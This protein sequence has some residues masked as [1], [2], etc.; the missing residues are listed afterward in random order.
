MNP[1]DLEQRLRDHFADRAAREP[2]GEPDPAPIVA[3]ARAGA[4]RPFRRTG[5]LALVGALA[6]ACVLAVVAVVVTG[7]DEDKVEMDPATPTTD[8][9]RPS[10]STTTA[11]TTPPSSQPP[12]TTV[13]DASAP[14]APVESL[15]VVGRSVLGG[16]D[17]AR[18]VSYGRGLPPAPVP[19]RAGDQYQV[20][21]LVGP[22]FTAT[23]ADPEQVACGGDDTYLVSVGEFDPGAPAMVAVRGVAAPRPRPVTVLDP[24][25]PEYRNAAAQVLAGLGVDVQDPAVRQ[26][27]RVDLDGDGTDEVLVRAEVADRASLRPV[28]G[29][30]SVVFLRR[31][32]GGAVQNTVV[33]SDVPVI[34][35][36]QIR[37]ITVYDLASVADLN[38]D[39]RMEV[40]LVWSYY[41]G[42][43]VT[44]YE[45]Q[46]DRLAPVLEA[47]CGA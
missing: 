45:L 30:Y 34:D 40:V 29:D 32:V 16:W 12:V 31:L 1:P 18:W 6:A 28:A 8:T 23:G 41:E 24:T 37:A 35:P 19:A 27:V 21:G 42:G 36:D 11:P 44:G 13:A 26:V 10:P 25:A 9:T 2:L 33:A 43:G 39:G 47:G 4:V 14:A 15:T 46:G 3:A 38:G 7:D 20:L 22:P 5:R 17:G